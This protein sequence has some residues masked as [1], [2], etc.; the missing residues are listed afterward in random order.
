MMA[1]W[2]KSRVA[3]AQGFT[4]IELIVV[5]AIIALLITIVAP[6][7]MRSLEKSKEAVLKE[8]LWVM[9][10]ALD[11]YY[12]DLGKYPNSLD[13]LVEQKYLRAVPVDPVTDSSTTWQ[14]VPPADPELGAVFNIKSG[15]SG[16]STAGT[17]YSDW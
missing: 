6:R 12:G 14:V 17:S 7:Y 10:D 8:D 13:E 11:K 5:M 2:Q 4:L 16:T 9:R 3:R 1:M 15:A